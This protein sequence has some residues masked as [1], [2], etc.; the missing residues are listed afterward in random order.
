MCSHI[1][2]ECVLLLSYNYRSFEERSLPSTGP[3]ICVQYA[4]TFNFTTHSIS[5]QHIQLYNTLHINTA[6]STLQHA[7]YQYKN[8]CNMRAHSTLQHTPYQYEN[9]FDFTTHSIQYEHTF[10]FTT[11]SISKLH[12]IYRRV[13]CVVCMS[14]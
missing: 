4:S 6:H 13:I 8:T 3:V 12:S 9:L 11:H 2:I 14:S 1:H 5:I 10:N 7:P